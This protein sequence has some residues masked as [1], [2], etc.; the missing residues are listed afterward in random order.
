[1]VVAQH[2]T[3]AVHPVEGDG[4]GQSEP[5]VAINKGAVPGQRVKQGRSLGIQPQVGVGA[6]GGG[7][8]AGEGRFQQPVI[9]DGG[10]APQGGFCYGLVA[11]A[12]R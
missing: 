11:A 7:L 4:P 8:W 3:G 1:L 5:L 12:M 10:L 2:E 9:A 6:E